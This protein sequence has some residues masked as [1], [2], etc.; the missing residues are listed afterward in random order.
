MAGLFADAWAAAAVGPVPAALAPLAGRVRQ[1][2]GGWLLPMHRAGEEAGGVLIRAEPWRAVPVG[3]LPSGAY[4]LVTDAPYLVV[5]V[6]VAAAVALAGAVRGGFAIVPRHDDLA[7]MELPPR[8]GAVLLV[9]DPEIDTRARVR[10]RGVVI[11]NPHFGRRAGLAAAERAA[12]MWAR[13]GVCVTIG[14]PD[15]VGCDHA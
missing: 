7:W 5:V 6:G 2:I 11:D 8:C 1:G 4:A 9:P 15:A 12:A 3:P 13:R 10:R 14:G